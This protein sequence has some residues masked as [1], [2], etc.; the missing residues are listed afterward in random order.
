[1]D[2]VKLGIQVYSDEDARH[3]RTENLN[4]LGACRIPIVVADLLELSPRGC[5]IG[6]KRDIFNIGDHPQRIL[7]QFAWTDLICR[8]LWTITTDTYVKIAL[9]TPYELAAC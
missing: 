5:I 8:V 1:M 3:C 4:I 7:I 9:S 6:L 2:T